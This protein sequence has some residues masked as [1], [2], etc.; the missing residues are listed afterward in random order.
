M[1]L[2]PIPAGIAASQC[3]TLLDAWRELIPMEAIFDS[4]PAPSE[5]I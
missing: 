1:G 4:E 3:K 5:R 2:G